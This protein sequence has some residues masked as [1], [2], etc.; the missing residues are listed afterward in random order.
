MKK[1]ICFIQKNHHKYKEPSPHGR[2]M[3]TLCRTWHRATIMPQMKGEERRLH[4]NTR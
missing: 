3:R 1:V 2:T 4:E